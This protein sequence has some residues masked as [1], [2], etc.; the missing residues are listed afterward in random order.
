MRALLTKSKERARKGIRWLGKY[1]KGTRDKGTIFK[2]DPTRGLEVYV[3]ADFAGNW[4]KD[5][6]A[7][8]RDTARSRHGY[9]IMYNGCLII[10]KSQ[11]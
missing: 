3:D 6:A 11:L 4:D 1:L 2:P 5:E 9:I 10:W 8:D 7:N